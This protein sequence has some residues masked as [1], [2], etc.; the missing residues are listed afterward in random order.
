MLHIVFAGCPG[1]G[2]SLLANSLIGRV[3]FESGVRVTTETTTILKTRIANGVKYSDTPGLDDPQ[4]RVQAAREISNA[5]N[6][7][8]Q[9]KLV[10]VATLESGRIRPSDIA[11]ID[12]IL[13]A[14]Q[15]VN[16]EVNNNFSVIINRCGDTELRLLQDTAVRQF[17]AGRLGGNFELE[18]ERVLFMRRVPEAVGRDSILFIGNDR[19]ELSVFSL[20]A[21]IL[22]LKQPEVDV[23]EELYEEAEDEAT[24]ELNRLQRE[25]DKV[26]SAPWW[27]WYL[28]RAVGIVSAV[29]SRAAWLAMRSFL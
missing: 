21:P 26:N 6:A 23:R 14:V 2:K 29:V 25:L 9:L 7:E 5:I 4:K 24:A 20:D 18:A 16:V 10:F 19:S 3:E 1:T 11:T 28:K 27:L 12:V 17:V 8:T 15:A 22:Q 13:S